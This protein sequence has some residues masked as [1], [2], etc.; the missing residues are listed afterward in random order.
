MPAWVKPCDLSANVYF[1]ECQICTVPKSHESDVL[2]I[3]FLLSTITQDSV[4]KH[5]S[6]FQKVEYR[7]PFVIT[8]HRSA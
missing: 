3:R 6:H 4:S 2:K 1:Y 5:N 8:V 7:R